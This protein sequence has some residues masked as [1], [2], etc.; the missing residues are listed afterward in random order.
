MLFRSRRV[1]LWARRTGWMWRSCTVC[2]SR[3]DTV[4]ETAP[5]RCWRLADSGVSLTTATAR[6][7]GEQLYTVQNIARL[8]DK[9]RYFTVICRLNRWHKTWDK[10]YLSHYFILPY[11]FTLRLFFALISL[12]PYGVPWGRTKILLFT[13]FTFCK[14]GKNNIISPFHSYLKF[15][16]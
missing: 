10:P 6:P 13:L 3:R 4:L 14:T 12:F 15:R 7:T 5:G 11:T 9:G 1:R 8:K 2:W 16:S